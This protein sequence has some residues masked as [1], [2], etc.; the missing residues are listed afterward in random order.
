[1]SKQNIVV[2]GGGGAGAAVAR[3][4]SAKLDSSKQTL[5]LVTARPYSVYLPAQLRTV[6]S[7]HDHLEKTSFIPYVNLCRICL[8]IADI[9]SDMT[10]FSSTTTV[11]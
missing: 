3:Q 5:T 1:M 9:T 4:L 7:D 8:S 2:V 6:V 10:S 11:L